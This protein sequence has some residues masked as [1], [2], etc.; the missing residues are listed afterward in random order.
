MNL[1]GI[2]TEI[3]RYDNIINVRENK[4]VLMK[5]VN[6]LFSKSY[7]KVKMTLNKAAKDSIVYLKKNGL[8]DEAIDIINKNLNTNYNNIG[9]LV[10]KSIKESV[11]E[12]FSDWF[13]E[14]KT[15]GYNALSFYPLLTMFLE[16]DKLIKGNPDASMRTTVIY[17]IIWLLVITGKV[18]SGK[19]SQKAKIDALGSKI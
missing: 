14:L 13:K 2:T 9:Q 4:S 1:N 11:N 12:G 17:F 15:N 19:Y 6:T 18:V 16:F 3:Q 7:G 5:I 8:E 10:S